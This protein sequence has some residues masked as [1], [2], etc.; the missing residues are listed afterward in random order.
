MASWRHSKRKQYSTYINKWV[1]YCNKRQINSFHT[2][3]NHILEF[4]TELF[5]SRYSYETLNSARSALLSFCYIEDGY[6][7][8]SHPL[9][10]KFLTGIYNFRSIQPRYK[11]F[12]VVSLVFQ[13]LRT[14]TPVPEL[15][16]KELSYQL[17]MLIALTQAS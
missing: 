12:W 1:Q 14:L 6:T 17:F 7:I 10:V 9:V 2:S 3:V 16:L 4:L 8:G 11:E 15:S 13:Y 5:H